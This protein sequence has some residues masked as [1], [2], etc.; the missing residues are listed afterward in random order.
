MGVQT[1][2]G[3]VMKRLVPAAALLS[4][5]AASAA[6]VPAA[7]DVSVI[8]DIVDSRS[9]NRIRFEQR[10]MDHVL[11]GELSFRGVADYPLDPIVS[12][13]YS[14]GYAVVCKFKDSTSPELDKVA[15]FEWNRRVT[16][17]GTIKGAEAKEGIGDIP[18]YHFV[19]LDNCKFNTQQ[20]T[21][22]TK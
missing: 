13:N 7:R 16:L 20:T 12:F 1:M 15:D 3:R 8:P 18:F 21:G 17:V 4:P 10:Y 5:F 14:K 2:T 11:S 6:N 9:S 19:Y 22:E